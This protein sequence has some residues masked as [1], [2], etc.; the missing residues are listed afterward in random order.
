MNGAGGHPTGVSPGF[1]SFNSQPPQIYI[2]AE[3]DEFDE[4]TIQIWKDEG[5]FYVAA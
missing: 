2:T 4:K 5:L 1:L 3:D